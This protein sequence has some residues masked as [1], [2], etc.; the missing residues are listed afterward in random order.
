MV[1]WSVAVEWNGHRT[2]CRFDSISWATDMPEGDYV[3]DAGRI[4]GDK[5]IVLWAP[6]GFRP[7]V[8]VADAAP[9]EDAGTI[10]VQRGD[11][12]RALRLEA[13]DLGGG[14][15][16]RDVVLRPPREAERGPDTTRVAGRAGPVPEERRFEFEALPR[17]FWRVTFR[18]APAGSRHV[19][20][21]FETAGG[22]PRAA[23]ARR[24]DWS[25]VVPAEAL[26]GR[27]RVTGSAA[28]RGSWRRDG[29]ALE[30]TGGPGLERSAGSLRWSVPAAARFE[31]AWIG[32]T[33]AGAPATG[34]AELAPVAIAGRLEPERL[35]LRV[36]VRLE[37]GGSGAARRA[38]IGCFRLSEDGWEWINARLDSAG[39]FFVAESR[40]LGTFAILADTLAPRVTP[41]RPPGRVPAAPYDRWALEAR[42]REEGSGVD[43]RASYFEVDGARVPTEWDAEE[44][45]LRW[46]PHRR[47]K[48]GSHA[49]EVVATDRAGNVG[50]R[51]GTFVLD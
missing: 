39:A 19:R 27:W 9:G 42:L 7:R 1:P 40:R 24:A 8:M 45:T 43:A 2:E 28:A 17:G 25:A 38:G 20:F 34:Q 41:L 36:P 23:T 49:F 32:E 48:S 35:P 16:R 50:R 15:A 4:V 29:P 37:L 11:P 21:E 44:R 31:P 6:A 18:G 12:P 51:A 14:I 26:G 30:L 22:G 10:A 33:S 47:P 5:G 13:R 46:R 3:Y